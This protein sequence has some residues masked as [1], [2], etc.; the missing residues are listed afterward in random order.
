K[1]RS[2][3]AGGLPPGVTF[4]PA[5]ATLSGAP[6]A[7]GD[8]SFG[9]QVT[10]TGVRS[11]TKTF[12]LTSAPTASAPAIQ[13]SQASLDFDAPADGDQPAPQYLAIVAANQQP[14]GAI[15]EIDSGTPGSPPPSWLSARFVSAT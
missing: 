4:N 3:V 9:I 5:T 14:L 12:S 1:E 15:I 13:V 8:F 11:V 6:T 2:A 10:D 7:L